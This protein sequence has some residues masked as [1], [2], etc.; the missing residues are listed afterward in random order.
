MFIISII[1]FTSLC[2][3]YESNDSETAIAKRSK[4]ASSKYS[5]FSSLF[6]MDWLIAKFVL[7]LLYYI[8]YSSRLIFHNKFMDLSALTGSF[9]LY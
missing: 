6:I 1:A 7:I 5:L 8:N 2:F 4:K 9:M 3:S